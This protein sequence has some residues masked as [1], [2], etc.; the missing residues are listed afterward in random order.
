M[1]LFTHNPKIQNETKGN[2]F[3][4]LRKQNKSLIKYI[5]VTTNH[6]KMSYKDD[7]IMSVTNNN[8]SRFCSPN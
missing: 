8:K 6:M 7:K 2:I 4:N 5:K 3:R 1:P